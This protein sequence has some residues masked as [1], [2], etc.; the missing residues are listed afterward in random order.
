MV[1]G[2]REVLHVL[3]LLSR[4]PELSFFSLGQHAYAALVHRGC[5]APLRGVLLLNRAQFEWYRERMLS[6]QGF[7]M[8]A[9]LFYREEMKYIKEGTR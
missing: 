8:R 2:G 9:F 4:L 3:W 5:Q 7:E 1:K 6:S